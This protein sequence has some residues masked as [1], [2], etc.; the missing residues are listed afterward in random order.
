M[1]T[2][3]IP[4][5]EQTLKNLLAAFNGESNAAAHYAAFAIKADEEGYLK[6]GSLFRATSRAEQIHAANHAA[7]IQK[8]GGVPRATILPAEIKTSVENLKAAIEGELYEVEVMYPDFIRE[9]EAQKY[10]AARRTFCFALEAEKEHA[11]LFAKILEHVQH[12]VDRSSQ[13]LSGKA[14]CY[15]CSACGFT[16]DQAEFERCPVC[17]HPKDEFELVN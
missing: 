8:L 16:T 6:V 2:P 13:K 10:I 7:V 9:A 3:A 5:Y 11:R 4:A 1:S 17:G 12:C 15:V 14:I